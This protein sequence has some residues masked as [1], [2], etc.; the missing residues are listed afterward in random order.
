M[1]L[2]HSGYLTSEYIATFGTGLVENEGRNRVDECLL[3]HMA[4]GPSDKIREVHDGGVSSPTF[5]SKPTSLEVEVMNAY[6]CGAANF[7]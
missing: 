1:K 5:V 6:I 3:K 7:E 2:E 4:V